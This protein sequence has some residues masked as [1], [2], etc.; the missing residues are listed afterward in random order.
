[1]TANTIFMRIIAATE[2]KS[3]NCG[4]FPHKNTKRGHFPDYAAI[5]RKWSNKK[6]PINKGF[7]Q[8]IQYFQHIYIV[9]LYCV[10]ACSPP[11]QQKFE[12]MALKLNWK[13]RK[14]RAPFFVIR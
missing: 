11:L 8:G 12:V 2:I 9:K 3:N 10:S 5:F 14:P 7:D 1:M 6:Q 4:Y 13:E